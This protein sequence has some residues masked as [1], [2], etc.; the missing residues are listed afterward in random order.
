M[1]LKGKKRSRKFSISVILYTVS[2]VVAV[3][4]IALLVNNIIF[5]RTTVNNYVA[6]GYS[7]ADVIKQLLLSQ[8]LPGIFE[9]IAVYGGISVVLLSMGIINK[10]VSKYLALLDKGDTCDVT[11]EKNISKTNTEPVENSEANKQIEFTEE[12]NINKA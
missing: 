3:I 8:L 9:P 11:A 5:F 4:G 2:I 10:K 6:Q 7:S 1:K 12:A